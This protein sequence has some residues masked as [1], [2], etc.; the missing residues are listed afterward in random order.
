[1]FN[2]LVFSSTCACV[3]VEDHSSESACFWSVAQGFWRLE[4]REGFGSDGDG[5][6]D[7]V[8]ENVDAKDDGQDDGEDFGI[9]FGGEF[10]DDVGANGHDCGGGFS[11]WLIEGL[12]LTVV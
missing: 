3:G 2:A 7:G 4:R 12:N 6:E 11:V 10:A 8:E 1:M 9:V 5:A